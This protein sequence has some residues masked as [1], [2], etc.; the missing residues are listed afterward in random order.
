MPAAPD[1]VLC[2]AANV[3]RLRDQ[4]A[5]TQMVAAE[6]CLLDLRTM[7]RIENAELDTSLSVLAR[8]CEGFGTE[9]GELLAAAPQ[10]RRRPRGRPPKASPRGTKR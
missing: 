5:W 10:P 2:L 4:R 1:L 8:L 6:R 3:R 9:P 7:Q